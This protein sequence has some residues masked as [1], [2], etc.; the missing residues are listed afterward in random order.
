MIVIVPMCGMLLQEDKMKNWSNWQM[1]S[2]FLKTM[3]SAKNRKK[4]NQAAWWISAK[5][6]EYPA[7]GHI[8]QRRSGILRIET[9]FR[10]I[11]CT[12]GLLFS[13]YSDLVGGYNRGWILKR[14]TSRSIISRE[15]YFSGDSLV[16][17]KSFSDER[18]D[19][20]IEG[21]LNV[22]YIERHGDIEIGLVYDWLAYDPGELLGITLCQYD[23]RDHLLS[24][25]D[26]FHE[27]PYREYSKQFIRYDGD[28]IKSVEYKH[29]GY[30]KADIT[31][32]YNE[33]MEPVHYCRG[34][35]HDDMDPCDTYDITKINRPW[36]KEFI[37]DR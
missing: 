4:W 11:Q 36:Y 21:V 17:V 28:H 8:W 13:W 9:G 29:T 18:L 20:Y 14:K 34:E 35:Y 26:Y 15:F 22:E 16:L 19:C 27:G 2:C 6:L 3:I 32:I 12:E 5:V 25:R 1:K 33:N 23:K 7:V 30:P 10:W 24:F 37:A 31:L